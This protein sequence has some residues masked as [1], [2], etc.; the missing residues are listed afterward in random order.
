MEDIIVENQPEASTKG[1]IYLSSE[2]ELFKSDMYN[3]FLKALKSRNVKNP[4]EFA[5]RL[6]TQT[7]LE[8][9]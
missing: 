5:K 1:K 8:S 6:T 3:A 7:I 9:N 4:E 2:K